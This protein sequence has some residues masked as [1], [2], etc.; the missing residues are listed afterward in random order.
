MQTNFC[1]C[2]GKVIVGCGCPTTIIVGGKG[3]RISDW[4]DR[5]KNGG[6]GLQPWE[7]SVHQR[8]GLLR[9][10]NEAGSIVIKDEKEAQKSINVSSIY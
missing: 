2:C 1:Y 7:C 5:V 10:D 6:F 9:I 3:N 8:R 4:D